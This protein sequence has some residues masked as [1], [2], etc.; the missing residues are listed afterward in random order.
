MST[1]DNKGT[2]TPE[3]K[4]ASHDTGTPANLLA[5]MLKDWKQPTKKLPPPIKALPYFEKRRAALSAR[6]PGDVILVP[7][8]HL[9][10]RANDTFYPFRPSSDFFYLTGC[11]QPDCVLALLPE[12]SGHRSVLYVY[13][14]PGKTDGSFFTDRFRGELW[15]GPYPG[16]P[17]CRALFGIA[18]T[19]PL[20]ELDSFLTSND[21]RKAKTVRVLRGYS[22]RLE[23]LVDDGR[24]AAAASRDSSDREM[25]TVLSEHRLRKDDWEVKQ[26]QSVVDSTKRGFEDVIARLKTAKTE[27]EVE[28]VFA[29]RARMEGNDVG[30]GTIAAAGDHAC[31][32][33]WKFNNG[34]IRKQDLL[35]LDAGIEG[36]SFYTA[37]ITRTLPIGGK[38]SKPQ[39]EIYD[40]VWRAQAAA[41]KETK[42]GR[43]FLAPNRAAM[44]VLAHGLEELGILPTSAEEAL[45]EENQFY[46]RYSLHNVSHML[47]LDVHDCAQARQETYRYGKLE[48]GMV[49]TVEPG[50]YFQPDDLTVPTKY[51]GIGV[52]IED[53]VV[54]TK[55]GHKNL[56]KNIPSES[57]AVEAWMKSVWAKAKAK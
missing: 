34:D 16:V 2:T 46:K 14:N 42:P 52:R 9:K 20:P 6:F 47:G 45:R 40:L 36:H 12:G 27:R 39:R 30:Y 57:K 38:F 44:E 50:L 31:V 32:L 35:L 28:G 53:D 17:E 41:F 24:S 11:A 21:V 55:T 37:D 23:K 22:D 1:F 7:T 29:L 15:E 3:T 33:H 18:D 25:A 10:V 26:L 48:A 51:R 5:F 54:L 19:R 8:G 56:S 43:D 49:I 4:K 13:P